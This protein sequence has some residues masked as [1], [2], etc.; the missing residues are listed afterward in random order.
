MKVAALFI[1]FR[2]G[3]AMGYKAP[4]RN[5]GSD[6][7]SISTLKTSLTGSRLVSIVSTREQ[8][9]SL[10]SGISTHLWMVL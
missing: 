3:M 1:A 8:Q 9:H 5:C 2:L 7:L 6:S 10:F 4:A